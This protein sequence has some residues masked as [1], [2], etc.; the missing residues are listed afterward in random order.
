M[1]DTALLIEDLDVSPAAWT[2]RFSQLAPPGVIDVVPAATTVLIRC[3]NASDLTQVR[4]ALSAQRVDADDCVASTPIELG[5]GPG[6]VEIPTRYDGIDLQWAAEQCA[7]TVDEL[8]AV[9]SGA[10]YRAEFIGFAPGFAYLAGLDDRLHLPRRQTPRI[11][12]PAGSV[13]ISAA[14]TAVYPRASPGG[15]H[16]LGSTELAMF[17]PEREP[18]ALLPAG[19][20]VRFVPL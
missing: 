2:Q 8:V 3:S 19:T 13:A 1:G 4:R 5:D 11:S 14:Y 10:T 7:L 15:W 6:V 18:P 16:L 12:V 20:A 9:H 17:T